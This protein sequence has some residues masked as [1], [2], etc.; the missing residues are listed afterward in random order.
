MDYK[1]KIRRNQIITV[2]LLA[3]FIIGCGGLIGFGNLFRSV[4]FVLPFFILFP[5]GV[6]YIIMHFEGKKQFTFLALWI[7][8]V[9][10]VT[11]IVGMLIDP[12]N[13]PINWLKL[14]SIAG[15]SW[16]GVFLFILLLTPVYSKILH[17]WRT[18]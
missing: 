5:T 1:T 2:F 9:F 17:I 4:L 12:R 13:Y 10:S 18:K 15:V 14:F 3:T 6:Y 7:G 11:S 16:V 8:F